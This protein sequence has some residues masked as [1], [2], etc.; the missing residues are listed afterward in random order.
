MANVPLRSLKFPGLDNTFTVPPIDSSLS[1]EGYAADAKAAGEAIA[2]ADAGI[3]Y[4]PFD[5]KVTTV[6][7]A[8]TDESWFTRKGY[9]R[10]SSLSSPG[11]ISTNQS[12]TT[13]CFKARQDMEIIGCEFDGYDSN[14][15]G[16]VRIS[17]EEPA[18]GVG[19]SWTGTLYDTKA[20][21]IPTSE[22]SAPVLKG[23]WIAINYYRTGNAGNKWVLHLQETGAKVLQPDIPLTPAMLSYVDNLA[24]G[25]VKYASAQTLSNVQKTQARENIGA[26]EPVMI[27]DTLTTQGAAADAKAA[28]DEISGL[29][30]AIDCGG[31]QITS[32]DF[33]RGGFSS[34]DG[35]ESNTKR[36]RLRNAIECKKLTVIKFPNNNLYYHIWFLSS[37]NLSTPSIIAKRSWDTYTELQVPADCYVYIT[38]ANAKTETSS[39]AIVPS[40]FDGAIGFAENNYYLG[41]INDNATRI[42]RITN[43]KQLLYISDVEQGGF[44]ATDYTPSN[45]RICTTDCVA[46]PYGEKTVLTVKMNPAIRGDYLFAVRAGRTAQNLSSN[47]YWYKSGD[48]VTFTNHEQYYRVIFANGY[49]SNGNYYYYDVAPSD[50]ATIQPVVEYSYMDD[51]DVMDTLTSNADNLQRLINSKNV[52]SASSHGGT[53]S[54]P[55]IFHVS[56]LHGDRERAK[57]ALDICKHCDGDAI[58]FSGDIVSNSPIDGVGWMHKLFA[59]FGGTPI[60][61][62]G[63]HEVT[64]DGITDEQVYEYF[65]QPSATKIGNANA[66]TYYYT[67]IASKQIRIIS[68]DLYQYGATTRSNTH[69]TS[70]QLA[71]ICS[72]LKTTPTGYGVLIV[73]HTPCVDIDSRIDQN[74]PAFFQP[75]RKYG[76]T[77]YD[78]VG[79]P[80]YDIIDAFN[81]RT[82]ISKTYEQ[83]GSPSSISVSDDFSSVDA[84][85]EFI[86]HITGHIHE[87]SVCYLPTQT[88]QLMLNITCGCAMSGGSSYPYLADDCDITRIPY[89]KTQDAINAYVI[90]RVGKR[91]R[92]VRIGGTLTYDMQK[93]EYMEIPYAD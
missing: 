75:L 79:A 11:Q 47:K 58:I 6:D 34:D 45:Q 59:G 9:I 70:E 29:K 24:D 93:R 91:V 27:D 41:K 44:R 33:E 25:T 72:A 82:T 78:I 39:T 52:L 86:A 18:S 68:V 14:H 43:N 30:D 31:V 89:D 90:D 16:S 17:N 50:I 10:H 36:I 21:N 83:T 15:W 76:F 1:Q 42:E 65:M 32:S 4:V 66:K 40:D 19:H 51:G 88:K 38:V 60:L 56:D 20:G 54:R 77:H 67:D 80:I 73:A 28:G 2:N 55:V 7:L 23:Q 13:Y 85:V 57:N 8:P 81:S 69:M 35:K 92:I 22:T 63:N 26:G 48:T 53:T 5:T 49:L 62:V 74:Y 12:Y 64:Q 71:Y 46:L 87:D 84:S 3:A 37:N 61:C